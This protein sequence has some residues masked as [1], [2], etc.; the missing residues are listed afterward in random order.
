MSQ[1][2]TTNLVLAT[3]GGLL[4]TA[5]LT[6]GVANAGWI[7]LGA[8]IAAFAI[9]TV[10]FA[11]L[12]RGAAQRRLDVL[13][14]VLGVWTA[15]ESRLFDGAALRWISFGS[16]GAL[17]VLAASGLLLH[18]LARERRLAELTAAAD[19]RNAEPS[20]NGSGLRSSVPTPEVTA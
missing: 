11:A 15:V 9:A 20:R 13:V 19:P 5:S 4:L 6:F 18:E 17:V 3:L 2:F 16:G 14:A 7:A 1:R 10:G 8:G 12:D